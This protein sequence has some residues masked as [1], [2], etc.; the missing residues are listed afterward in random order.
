[1][2]NRLKTYGNVMISTP[3]DNFTVRDVKDFLIVLEDL[4]VSDETILLDGFLTFEFQTE[5]VQLISCGEHNP[6][7]APVDFLINTHRCE[8]DEN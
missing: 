3:T 1:M 7:N 2:S 6:N 5:D 4:N 8:P